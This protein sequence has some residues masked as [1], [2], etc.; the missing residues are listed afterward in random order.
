MKSM[1]KKRCFLSCIFFWGIL[2]VLFMVPLGAEE[3][4]ADDLI[5]YTENFPPHN[6]MENGILQGASVEILELI[7]KKLGASK[8]KKEIIIGPWA[9]TIKMLENKPNMV[10][11]GMGFSP[12][13]ANKFHC[14]GPYY[15]HRLSLIS[16]RNHPLMISTLEQAKT[17]LIGV[18]RQD[19]GHQMLKKLGFKETNLDLSSDI[20]QLHKKFVKNRFGLICYIK[21]TYFKYLISVGANP[22]DFKAIYPISVMESGF[23]FSKQIPLPLVRQFQSALDELKKDGSVARVLKKYNM[24]YKQSI[25]SHL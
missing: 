14:V 4:T 22:D 13:R 7:W 20:A 18:V 25:S 5:Y 15:S 16:K 24:N 21:N 11:F 1:T 9:R 10:L 2:S 19:M 17:F 23:G 6:Y 12:E 8:N 3:I